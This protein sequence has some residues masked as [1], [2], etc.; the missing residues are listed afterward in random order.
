MGWAM[1]S[2]NLL[3]S[4]RGRSVYEYFHQALRHLREQ[5]LPVQ[6]ELT[7]G[8]EGLLAQFL[9]DVRQDQISAVSYKCTTCVTL[10]AYC[11]L[12]AE[13]VKDISLREVMLIKPIDLIAA[14][15]G[16]PSYR[17][18]RAYLAVGA[19]HSAVSKARQWQQGPQ[20]SY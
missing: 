16:V 2:S 1:A 14:L 12:L 18:D 6:G 10:V 9:L 19:L 15:P 11:E 3:V 4:Q 17:Y 7:E 5:T 8:N 13:A 20:A